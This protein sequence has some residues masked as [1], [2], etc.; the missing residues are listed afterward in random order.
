MESTRDIKRQTALAESIYDE[1]IKEQKAMET[2]ADER[3]RQLQQKANQLLRDGQAREA[4]I[5][6]GVAE[7]FRKD[8]TMLSDAPNFGQ[9]SVCRRNQIG[10]RHTHPCE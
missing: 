5:A 2:T 4:Q 8:S 9:C 1:I 10:K 6:L 7:Q 3:Y